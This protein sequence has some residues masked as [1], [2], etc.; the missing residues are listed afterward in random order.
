MTEEQI[1]QILSDVF[2][3][4]LEIRTFE[5]SITMDE[6]QEWDSLKQI[7]LV[8]GIESAFGI[9]IQFDDSIKMISGKSILNILKKYIDFG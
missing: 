6:V 2:H 1:I 3:K 9:E 5:L 7:Q 4:T 8:S